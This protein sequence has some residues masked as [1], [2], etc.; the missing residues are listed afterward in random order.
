MFQR[1]IRW[2]IWALVLMSAGGL[3]KHL[4]LHP[5]AESFFFW[6]PV[7]VGAFNIIVLPFLFNRRSTAS[8]AY[9]INWTT[10]FVGT[11]TMA[12]YSI[13]GWQREVNLLTIVLY[14]TLGDILILAARLPI[15]EIIMD[16]YRE[17]EPEERSPEQADP[18][19]TAPRPEPE[20]PG[21]PVASVSAMAPG[22]RLALQIIV[23]AL[24]V[25][26]LA[27]V[28]WLPLRH[29]ARVADAIGPLHGALGLAGRAAALLAATLI[30]TQFVFGARL[31]LLDEAFGLDRVLRIHRVTGATAVVLALL[32]PML[33]YVTPQYEY[34]AFSLDR[35]PE[36]LGALALTALLFIAVTSIWRKLLGLRYE[37]WHRLHYLGF[38]VVVL[39]GVHSLQLGSDLF[40]GPERTVWMAVL[41]AYALLFVWARV[42]RPR[43]IAARRWTVE[44]VAPV[45]HDTWRLDLAPRGHRGIRQLPGQFGLLTLHRDDAPNER[46][47][48]TI[49]SPPREDGSVSFTIKQSGDYTE[50]IGETPEGVSAV[51]EGPWGQFSHLRHGGE[52]LVMIAG[53]VGITPILSMI[54]HMAARGDERSITLIWGNRTE[55]DILYREEIEG[56]AERLDLRV[57]HVLS[58]QEDY[59]GETGHLD[60]ALLARLLDDGERSGEVYLCGPPPMMALVRDALGGLGIPRSRIHSERFEL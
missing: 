9:V 4:R 17:T 19:P 11:V 8:A 55:A 54:R 38:A 37:T 25:A 2:P 47:P 41:G 26:L 48:F 35:W 7:I 40:N 24:F 44:R 52:R 46:H 10:V 58:E 30:M 3:L 23:I 31:R 22:A 5:P 14:S 27:F 33:L 21:A 49:S 32:H 28:A 12:F 34:G 20:P 15:G 13:A 43:I 18:A 6:I 36:A 53:G 16:H 51:V 45:S 59:A 29:F 57:I 60:A 56:L 50:R 1:E 42:I 39:A